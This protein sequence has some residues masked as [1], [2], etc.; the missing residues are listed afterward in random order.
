[1]PLRINEQNNSK[2]V[3][4][5]H[6]LLRSQD[7]TSVLKLCNSPMVWDYIHF[8]LRGVAGDQDTKK[9]KSERLNAHLPGS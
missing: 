6:L 4:T 3:G 9:Q 2:E 7:G 5:S 8:A 1:M